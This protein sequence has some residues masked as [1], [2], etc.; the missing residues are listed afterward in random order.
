MRVTIALFLVAGQLA[1]QGT[2]ARTR[3]FR[4]MTSGPPETAAA[5][6]TALERTRAQLEAL[7]FTFSPSRTEVVL[8]PTREEMEAYA[9]EQ[10]VGFFQPG[11]ETSFIVLA[12]KAAADPMK[13]LAHEL[14]HQAMQPVAG[15]HPHWLREGLAELLSNL[16]TVP[17]GIKLGVPLAY[18][19]EALHHEQQ[20]RAQGSPWFYARCW[21]A[22]HRLVVRRFSSGS[23]AQ[24]LAAL[25]APGDLPESSLPDR[26][27]AEVLPAASPAIPDALPVVRPLEAW[28]REHR[29]A[30]M[31]RGS[32]QTARAREALRALRARFPERSEPAESLGAL[33]MDALQYDRAEPWLAE[34][35]RLGSTDAATHYRYSLLLM[36]PGRPADLAARHASRAVELDPGPPLYW[37]AKAQAEMQLSRWDEARASLAA[38][39]RRAADP[40][41]QERRSVELAEIERRREQELR[42]PPHPSPPQVI[43]RV[44][45]RPTPE[46]PPPGPPATAVLPRRPVSPAWPPPGTSLFWG[47]VRGVECAE[48]LK[49]ITVAN[50]RFAVRVRERP[51]APARLV[52]P[53]RNMRRI[54]CSLKDARVAVAYRPDN[55][56]LVAVLFEEKKLEPQMNTEEH[57]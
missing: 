26:F 53:P 42:P 56:D 33:E 49:I 2:E 1:A 4:V 3:H 7:G 50:S 47:R 30:E 44:E 55:S 39:D 9:P 14:A 19:V 22:A 38:M 54:P 52:S 11:A 6:T 35:V 5:A 23:L 46:A 43:V 25:D 37:L 12:W 40:E 16:E 18:H 20:A 28:E 29:L 32:N 36:R 24:R 57:R 13:S 31:W 34:A 27:L 45:A 15:R 8:F 17:G 51:E 41:L 21:L 48:G 10:A